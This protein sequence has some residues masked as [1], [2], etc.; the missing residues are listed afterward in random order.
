MA[1][2]RTLPILAAICA[3]AAF[4]DAAPGVAYF[5]TVSARVPLHVVQADV[6]R[7]DVRLAVVTPADGIGARESW[8]SLIG[9]ARPAAALTGTYFDTRTGVPVGTLGFMGQKIHNGLIGTAFSFSPGTLPFIQSAKPN[10]HFDFPQSETFL[11]A[12]PRLLTNGEPTLYP[13]AEGFQDPS[14]FRRAKRTAVAT[15]KA[16]KLLLVATTKPVL[17]RE[18]ARALEE[19]GAV[20]AMCMDGGSSSALYYRGKSFVAPSRLL[21]NAL[22]VYDSDERYEA[23]ASMLNPAFPLP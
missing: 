5:K 13:R 15:S 2:C 20:D 3:A 6:S 1:R 7:K 18:M 23:R 4:A 8:A 19:M 10:T 22:V 14:V 12:G 11:R 16:G 9:R 21:T 17:L